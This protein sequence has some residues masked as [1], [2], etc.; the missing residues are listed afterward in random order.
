MEGF[1]LAAIIAPAPA[2]PLD[3]FKAKEGDGEI[4]FEDSVCLK[5]FW[6]ILFARISTSSPLTDSF[7][8]G[9]GISGGGLSVSH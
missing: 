3:S 7:S 2:A 9:G 8:V 4:A 1:S 6:A 5:S